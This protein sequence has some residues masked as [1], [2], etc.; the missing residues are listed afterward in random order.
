MRRLE[1]AVT[2]GQPYRRGPGGPR[3]GLSLL[4]GFILA[5]LVLA[6][7]AVYGFIKPAP[8]IGNA[9]VLVD[10]EHG[11]AYVLRGGRLHPALNLASALLAAGNQRKSD[12]TA[13]NGRPVTR[14]VSPGTLAKMAKGQAL[15]IS[16]A[17]NRIPDRG[18]LVD[19]TWT[20]CDTSRVDPAQA[21]SQP[22]RLTTTAVLGQP[23][24]KPTATGQ[25]VVV[26][27]DRGHSEF[28]LLG[29]QRFA[30]PTDDQPVAL[31]LG[32]EGVTPRPIS[33]GLL[34]AIPAGPK[35]TTPTIDGSGSA[36]PWDDQL[37][38][39]TVFR[40]HRASEDE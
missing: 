32:L 31:A 10:S 33:V 3:S 14:A 11:G 20:V 35:L 6:G 37:A 15:G 27:P 22:P 36:V 30:I 39:G 21:P 1:I 5:V 18:S 16:G 25:A 12:G 26:T 24:A 38:V 19:G 8:S 9:T 23:V 17:P 13:T 28:L 7:F 2:S 40:V 4:V 34:D 29:G